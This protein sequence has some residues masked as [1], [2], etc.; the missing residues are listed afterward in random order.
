MNGDDTVWLFNGVQMVSVLF[1]GLGV[2]WADA[3]E[4]QTQ[5]SDDR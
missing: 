1:V 5:R 3:I 2:H 4:V